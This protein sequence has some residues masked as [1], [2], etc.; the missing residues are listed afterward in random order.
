MIEIDKNKIVLFG[1]GKI[2][3]SFI[4]QLFSNGG[5]EVVFVDV[6]NPVIDELNRR[7]NYNVIIKADKEEILNIKNVRGVYAEDEQDVISEVASAGIVAISV[8]LNGL[9]RIFP[10]LSQGLITR[11]ENHPVIP[12][13]II[14]A[15]NMRNADIYFRAELLKLLPLSYPFDKLVGLVETSIGKMVPIM[16]KKDL[17]EDILQIFAEPYNT[18][19]L[20]KKG[21][22]NNIPDIDGL[23]PRENMKAWVDRKLFIHNL[24]HSAAAYIGYVFN[25]DFVYM[26]EALAVRDI[27]NKVRATMLQSGDILM[28]IYPG[29]FTHKD[30]T[31]H[32]DDLLR[33][34]QNRALGDTIFRVGSDLFR[35]LGPEDRLSGAI[36]TA[37]SLKK[38][39]EKI[40]FALVCGFHFRA[41]DEDGNMLKE[42]I[43]FANLYNTGIENVLTTVCGFDSFENVGLFRDAKIIESHLHIY[44]T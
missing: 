30:M 9:K 1:A 7:R 44:G 27:Y 23:A 16:Q 26:Y 25:P 32:I 22:K 36:K 28:E 14:I 35:K 20:N 33:R 24:G 38:P 4:G 40:L 42:D 41:Q 10:L 3:R 15:E 2:G 34:F 13:D 11:Y 37:I 31:D 6:Y 12:L 8:G 17:E 19:I 39:Y 5:F 18:L 21:F 43:E 29:E